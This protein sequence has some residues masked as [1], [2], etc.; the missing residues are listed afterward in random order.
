M[1][2]WGYCAGLLRS[3]ENFFLQYQ[4]L[5]RWSE[6]AGVEQ[7]VKHIRD[8][9]YGEK[10]SEE[11]LAQYATLLDADLFALYEE[12]EKLVPDRRLLQ[13]A[14]L[15]ED[16][17]NVKL[18][19]K[20]EIQ[21]SSVPWELLSDRGNWPSDEVYTW[22][23]EKLFFKFPNPISKALNR[24]QAELKNEMN[25]QLVDFMLDSAF[26]RYRF[27]ILSESSDYRSILVAEKVWVDLENLKNLLRAKR[28][29]VEKAVV[30]DLLLQEGNLSLDHL[31]HIYS[32]SLEDL[33][34]WI[35][36]SSYGSALEEGLT[37]FQ[38]GNGYSLIEK[39]MDERFVQELARFSYIS[40][41]AEVFYRYL[42][43]KKMEIKNLNILFIGVL[44]EIEPDH[45]KGRIRNAGF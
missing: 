12:F 29:G 33:V 2:D 6:S 27:E 30:N 19:V 3:Y 14:R 13:I 44:N 42:M 18:I 20:S 45:I 10:I 37:A 8:S 15:G 21:S 9:V 11:V 22:I 38:E 39:Q 34:D 26:T 32:E 24:I 41:G 36:K 1:V 28:L 43:L 7:F 5:L 16:L 23:E 4:T 31:L 35:R 25:L 40:L 17:K